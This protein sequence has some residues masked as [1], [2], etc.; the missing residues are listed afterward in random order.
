MSAGGRGPGAV[1]GAP[2]VSRAGTSRGTS[3]RTAQLRLATG[4]GPSERHGWTDRSLYEDL[5]DQLADQLPS[6]PALLVLIP[7]VGFGGQSERV[8]EQTL[9]ELAVQRAAVPISVV[10]LVNRPQARAGDGTAVRAR[11]LAA[12]LGSSSV[13]FAVAELVLPGRPRLGELRQMLLDAVTTVQRLDPSATTCVVADDDIVRLPS[14]LLAG[15]HRAVTGQ[16]GVDAAV[17][18]VLFDSPDVPAPMIPDFFAADAL[19]ALLAARLLRRLFVDSTNPARRGQFDRY[20]ESIA[21]SGNLAVRASAVH[22]SGGFAPLNE[23]TN[24]VRGVHRTAAAVAGTWDFDPSRENVLID[25]HRNALHSNARRALAAYQS[26][27]V[28]SIGQ[29]RAFRFHASRIDPV[30]TASPITAEPTRISALRR[31][32]VEEVVAKID[33]MLTATLS[34]F[35]IDLEVIEECLAALG[36]T[37]RS[38]SAGASMPLQVRTREVSSLLDRL[39]MVQ[40]QVV[41]GSGADRPE[42]SA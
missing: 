19:R 27:G 7:T 25:L 28:P 6:G 38:V 36:L 21:L 5:V 18:P 10:L 37:M 2:P 24:L 4:T 1:P 34:Y 29:W 35:P 33:A 26:R 23:I 32:D 41:T 40:E 14:G 16:D 22:D 12:V 8:L 30:R 15:L 13:H 31:R 3:L 11:E 42:L 9:R 17:G 39:R 20:A